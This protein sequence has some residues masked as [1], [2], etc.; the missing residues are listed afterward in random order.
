MEDL[1]LVA[2]IVLV[3][4]AATVGGILAR[5][6]GQPVLLGYIIAGVLIGPYTPGAVADSASVELLANLG[7]A[8]LMFAMG[9]EFSRDEL[10][11]VR[12]LAL[13]SGS[14]QFGLT[15]GLGV[16]AGL[17]IGWPLPAAILLG[18]AFSISSSIVAI[19]LL[20]GRGQ[21]ETTGGRIALGLG[22]VQDLAVVPLLALLPLLS[23]PVGNP[24]AAAGSAI[25]MAAI[26]LALVLVVGARIA[27]K[28]FD[29]VARTG[30]HELFVMTVAVAALGTG[31][32]SEEAGLSFALGAFLAGVVVS[33]SEFDGQVLAQIIPLRDLFASV[34]F[35]AVGMLIDPAFLLAHLG[36]ALILLTVLVV[37]KFA[38]VVGALMAAGANVLPATLAGS[39]LAQMGEFSFVIAGIGSAFGILAEDQY[40]MILAVALASIVLASPLMSWSPRWARLSTRGQDRHLL[41]D[42][43][44]PH[45]AAE[46]GVDVVICG[47]GRIGR[48]VVDMV[49][50]AD[51]SFS[52]I[53][54]DP[55]AVRSLREEG[56]R[57]HYGDASAEPV[58]MRAGV[59]E[60]R[61]LAIALPDLIAAT[62]V[63]RVAREINPSLRV[64][65]LTGGKK[66]IVTLER[67]G[68]HEVIHPDFEVSLGF[69][70]QVLRW[71]GMSSLDARTYAFSQ[72]DTFYGPLPEGS[73]A[74]RHRSRRLQGDEVALS[75]HPD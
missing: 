75:A 39:V 68:V 67:S 40:A 31:L 20:A 24:L 21:L 49:Q 3:L 56:H 50:G 47:Y 33:E 73:V 25:G 29:L 34:F 26:A 55:I 43:E 11:R 12:R 7:V 45:T 19:T 15:L 54:L 71:L 36:P 42:L 23:G 57:A 65:A 41:Q 66:G 1:T 6:L 13:V 38:I 74:R 10:M 27:P 59:G 46:H 14:L 60:A 72:R 9:L 17:A 16:L 37:G 2:T 44:T 53:D 4:G 69:G 63:V 61:I 18:A 70:R 35:V 32:A 48:G 28:V 22:V 52:V 5:R 64:I 51:F 30:S 58:Q 8:F 62:Q